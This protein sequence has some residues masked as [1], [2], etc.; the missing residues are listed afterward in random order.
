MIR[1]I[2]WAVLALSPAVAAAQEAFASRTPVTA[3]PGGPLQRLELPAA[4]LVRLQEPGFADLRIL[5][6]DGRPQPIALLDAR[7]PVLATRTTSLAPLPILGA[8]GALTVTGVSLRVDPAG[9]SRVVRV[10]GNVA[11]SAGAVLLG[12]LL[13]TSAAKG[14][15]TLLTL[16]VDAPPRQPVT[17]RVESS[18]DLRAW[19]PLGESVVYRA[20]GAA[21]QAK[22]PLDGPVE[23]Y[24]RITW[25]AT[26]PLLAPVQVTGAAL[27]TTGT[28]AESRVVAT[29]TGATLVDAHDLRL[30]LPF[31][32]PVAVLRVVPAADGLV[33]LRI[34]GRDNDEQAWVPIG[35]GTAYR[36]AARTGAAITLS[37]S[38]RQIRVEADARTSGFASVPGVQLV[39]APREV[40]V[41]LTG[42][43]PYTLAAGQAGLSAAYLPVAALA[44]SAPGVDSAALPQATAQ[45]PAATV[46]SLAAA[47]EKRTWVLWALLIVGTL[48]LGGLV[49]L[50]ARKA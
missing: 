29:L 45:A 40:A 44:A 35:E 13:D 8:P 30:T 39:F 5:D 46:A 23:R 9:T 31:A 25:S 28:A 34:F 42:R 37:D 14:P 33:P 21:A 2:L 27:T 3:A 10:D 41:L 38:Y 18:A 49:W 15:A 11:P 47:T 16:D 20:P 36:L 26:T 48:A 24:I 50:A 6:A 43:A 4:A 7:A 1:L 12:V 32:T 22:L 17:L 19:W